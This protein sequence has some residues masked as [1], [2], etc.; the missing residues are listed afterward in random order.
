MIVEIESKIRL[1][2]LPI[3]KGIRGELKLDR[4]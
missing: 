2:L 1:D 4:N 3:S